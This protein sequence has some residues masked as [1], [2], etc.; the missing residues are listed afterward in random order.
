ME[1]KNIYRIARKDFLEQR[2]K[3]ILSIPAFILIS[4]IF[5]LI[6]ILRP[7]DSDIELSNQLVPVYQKYYHTD[8]TDELLKFIL[9]NIKFPFLVLLPAFITPIFYTIDSI[10]GEKLN[11]TLE[12]IFV[13][14]IQDIEILVGKIVIGFLSGTFFSWILY[15]CYL[16][17]ILLFE[18]I[19]LFYHLLSLKWM[20]ISLLIVPTGAF[21][22]NTIAIYFSVQINNIKNAQML[23]FMAFIPFF[24]VFSLISHGLIIISA[25]FIIYSFIIMNF[26]NVLIFFLI[27]RLFKRERIILRY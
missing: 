16:I 9:L 24:I 6:N 26:L 22:M 8:S 21:F 18:S 27:I 19:K 11:R 4:F 23:G 17:F 2:K 14:P 12:S 1:A 15:I 7:Q 20:L 13:L 5:L 25:K 3:I 10:N